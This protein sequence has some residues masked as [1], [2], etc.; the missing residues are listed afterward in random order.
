MGEFKLMI[1]D[2]GNLVVNI[3]EKDMNWGEFMY[4]SRHT[5]SNYGGWNNKSHW[6]K[7]VDFLSGKE[8]ILK[9]YTE[10]S[11]SKPMRD[12]RKEKFMLDRED[13]EQRKNVSNSNISDIDENS[14]SYRLFS[15]LGNESKKEI[16]PLGYEIPLSS[17]SDGQLKIDILGYNQSEK[18]LEIIELKKGKNQTD[19]PFFAYIE[20]LCYGIQL[21]HC[22]ENI[23]K[24]MENLQDV[25]FDNINL[26]IAAPEVYYTYWKEDG[27]IDKI[28]KINELINRS[29]PDKK[30]FFNLKIQK[31]VET[32]KKLDD[33]TILELSDI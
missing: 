9:I 4:Y 29:I 10:Q 17:E 26:T 1:E 6:M 20:A 2:Q 8:E 5:N 15:S 13:S 27:S 22:Q 32:N 14:L 31:V 7:M 12:V 30:P 33:L 21:F 19:S 11:F 3:K 24:E 28:K 25:N 16:R 23:R 18:A